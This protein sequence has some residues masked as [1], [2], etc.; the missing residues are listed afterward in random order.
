MKML[1]EDLTLLLV[2]DLRAF[3]REIDLCPD[4]D[5]L[6]RTAP[7]V[8]NSVGNLALHVSGNL[9]HFVGAVLGATGYHRDRPLEFSRRSGSR[10]EVRREVEGTIDVVSGV[11][12]RLPADVLDRDYPE[13]VLGVVLSTRLFLL[14]LA[15]HLAHHLGQA[16]YLRRLL[17][18]DVTSSGPVS[19]RELG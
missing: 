7:G 11:L 5:V 12:A 17:T 8:T 4:D 18:G 2:R 13:A 1:T 9:C 14:H 16:G 15:T 10:E 6:W 3:A 19:P